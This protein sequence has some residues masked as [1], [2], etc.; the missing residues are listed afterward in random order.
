MG[1]VKGGA[2]NAFIASPKL[3][4]K[5]QFGPLSATCK[6]QPGTCDDCDGGNHNACLFNCNLW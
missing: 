1:P 6:C 5:L 3:R 4:L 2:M